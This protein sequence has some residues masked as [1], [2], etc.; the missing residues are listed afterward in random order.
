[1]K[2]RSGRTTSSLNQCQ[3]PQSIKRKRCF[4]KSDKSH[5]RSILFEPFPTM[6]HTK[7]SKKLKVEQVHDDPS[8]SSSK[9]AVETQ[10]LVN[11][12]KFLI[13][14]ST[15]TNKKNTNTSNILTFVNRIFGFGTNNEII[16]RTEL[17]QNM[18]ALYD[19]ILRHFQQI[20][21]FAYDQQ[22]RELQKVMKYIEATIPN[23][24]HSVRLMKTEYINHTYMIVTKQKNKLLRDLNSITGRLESIICKIQ[25]E[26][27]M[28][29]KENEINH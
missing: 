13:I 23:H 14:Q 9:K 26:F 21:K 28:I 1:M 22:S 12:I 5:Q 17:Y 3:N 15:K 29:H 2:L 10:T 8:S 27:E 16:M 25:F 11:N 19:Y 20:Y 6:I 18:F 24:L 4:Q 7:K